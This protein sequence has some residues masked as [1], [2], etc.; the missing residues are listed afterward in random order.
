MVEGKKDFFNRTI[1]LDFGGNINDFG[2]HKKYGPSMELI[3]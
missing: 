2:R 3:Y 1:V